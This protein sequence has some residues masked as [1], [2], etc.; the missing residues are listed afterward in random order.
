[1]LKLND[2]KN[3]TYDVSNKGHWGIG[4]YKIKLKSED[5]FD[6]FMELFK[7]AYDEKL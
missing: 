4:D 6:Y 2:Y 3:V 7:Q 1:M 5:D